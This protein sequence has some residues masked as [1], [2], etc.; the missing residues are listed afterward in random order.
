MLG[1]LLTS[2]DYCRNRHSQNHGRLPDA[3]E[4]VVVWLCLL[5]DIWRLPILLGQ[6]F[7]IFPPQDDVSYRL[8]PVR[9]RQLDLRC[10]ARPYDAGCWSRN[11]RPRWRGYRNR[12][13]YHYC[14]DD[15][16]ADSTSIHGN[17]W[18]HLRHIRCHWASSRGSFYRRR[19]LAMVVSEPPNGSAIDDRLRR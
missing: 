8:I 16:A 9:A 19:Q 3:G 2:S 4:R 7:Q 14:A 17:H 18:R 13:I 5:H 11:R 12:R 6:D 15:R 1:Y 10:C